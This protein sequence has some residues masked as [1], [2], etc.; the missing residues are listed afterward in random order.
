MPQPGQ[1]PEAAAPGQAVHQPGQVQPVAE[2]LGAQG[3][4][5]GGHLDPDAVAPQ[6]RG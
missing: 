6:L 3:G 1:A 4:P 5:G 2:A